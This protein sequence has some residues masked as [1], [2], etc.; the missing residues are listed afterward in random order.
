MISTVEPFAE[1]LPKKPSEGGLEKEKGVGIWWLSL[2]GSPL[3]EYEEKRYPRR[4]SLISVA[5][6]TLYVKS[7]SS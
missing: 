2:A 4:W 1:D 3:P 6:V 5:G 7:I